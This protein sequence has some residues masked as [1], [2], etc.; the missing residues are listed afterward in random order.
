MIKIDKIVK[1]KNPKFIKTELINYS[2]NNI[3]RS[4]ER[5]IQ[6]DS[7]H[8]LVN[9]VETKEIL[10]VKQVRIPVFLTDKENKGI[11]YE[12]C[13]G[14][15]DKDIPINEI[16]KEEVLEELGYNFNTKK[17]SLIKKLKNNVGT[18]GNNIYLYYVE[19]NE[20]EK[21]NEGGGL[22]DEDI[23]V[24]RLP[25]KK[26]EDFILNKNINTDST[27]MFLLTYWLIKNK[28]IL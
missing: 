26:V 22:E 6:H 15:I 5:V 16:A 14:L 25:Y 18:S 27:T 24:V 8:I 13:A 1:N 23:E 2:K 9:N 4:W 7:V 28:D 12:I 11:C 10:L 20:I 17:L 21:E 3:K 19:V